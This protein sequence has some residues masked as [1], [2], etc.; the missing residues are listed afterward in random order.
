[1]LKGNIIKTILAFGVLVLISGA[2]I[3]N[4]S[5]WLAVGFLLFSIIVQVYGSVFINSGFFIRTICRGDKNQNAIALTFDDGPVSGKT[6]RILEI[7]KEKNVKA[8]FFCIGKNVSTNE[9]IAKQMDEEGHLIGNHSY[10]HG[11]WFDLQSKD[12]MHDELA[13]T[14]K[15]IFDA[16]KKYPAFFRPPYGITNPNLAGAVKQGS[17]ETIGWSVRSFDTISKSK[18]KLWNRVTNN[19]K[20]GDIVLFHD[21]CDITI[22]MLPDFIDHVSKVGLKIVRLDELINK[23]P[24]V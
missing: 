9:T 7:L 11:K 18:E 20:S 22:E 4:W 6:E 23:K 1:M 2:F 3:W 10:H 8:S 5:A 19:L 21:Y 13:Q 14:D 15:A 24:Y 12:S 16:V 17:Y